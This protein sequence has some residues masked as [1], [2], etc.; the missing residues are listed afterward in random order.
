MKFQLLIKTKK[1]QTIKYIFVFKTLLLS[2]VCIWYMHVEMPT[3]IDILTF[4]TR[5]SILMWVR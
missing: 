3:I 1:K 5:I 4:M 2:D